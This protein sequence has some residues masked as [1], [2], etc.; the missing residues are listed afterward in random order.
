MTIATSVFGQKFLKLSSTKKPIEF[1]EMQRQ[2]NDWKKTHELKKEKGWKYFKRWENEM[3]MHTDASGNPVDSKIML[4]EI[5]KNTNTKINKSANK[6]FAVGWYPFGPNSVPN[7]LTGY[8]ENGIGRINCIA[9]EPGNSSTYYI[10]VGQGGVWKTTNNGLNWTPLTDNLPI[11]RVSDIA[12]DPNNTSTMYISLCDFEYVGIGLHLNGRKRN[13]HYGLG[14]YKTT[15]GGMNWQPTGLAFQLTQGDESLIRKIIVNQQ[16]SSK[17][18]ACG[19]NGMFTSNDGGTNWTKTMD[20]LFWDMVQDPVNPNMLFAAT[21]WINNSQDGF[22]AIYKSLDFGATWSMLT[23]GIPGT[24]VVQRVK[25]AISPSDP[26]YLYALTV[27]LSS[28]LHGI[29][30]TTN[31]GVSWNFIAPALNI[32]EYDEGFG[33]GGQGNYDL[34]FI[35]DATNRDK[36][37]AGGVNMWMSVDGCQNFNPVSH[38]TTSYGPTIHA[39]IHQIAQQP[40]TGN[41]FVCS[42]G[43]INR[44]TNVSSITWTDAQNGTQWPT[45]WANLS[46]GMQT[47]SFYRLSSSKTSTEVVVAGAQ[48]NATFLYDGSSWKTVYGGDGMDNWIDPADNNWIIASAQYGSFGLSMDGGNSFSGINPDASGS[49]NGE[50]TTPIIADDNSTGVL[51]A[52]Y[53][54]VSKSTDHGFNWSSISAFPPDPNSFYETEISALAVANTNPDVVVAAKRV[55]YEYATP[56]ALYHTSNGGT[57]WNDVTLGLPDSLYYTSVE[58]S[59]TDQNTFYITMA[60]FTSGMKVFKTSNAG[61]S[62]QN[63]SYNLPNIPTNCIKQIPGTNDLM[64][65]T[66]IGVYVLPANSTTWN[67]TSTGL[68]NVIISDIEFN[69]ALNKVYI[70]TFGRGIWTADLSEFISVKNNNVDVTKFELFPSPNSGSFKIKAPKSY[71]SKTPIKVEI[72]DICGKVVHQSNF[73]SEEIMNFDLKLNPGLYHAK[74]T[75]EKLYGVKSFVV[76]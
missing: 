5:L 51:Y 25:L 9:F 46:N 3:Q 19:V 52:G 2:F 66:D 15:D 74:I 48:D 4:T 64:L 34:G 71:K 62:W 23:T 63:I 76:Q 75:G 12:I 59:E 44:T 39:D 38:W 18:V 50:W 42:D 58:I 69:I 37:Y 10:G 65:A 26:N 57:T 27:D 56:G 43:G 36:I 16:N 8:M 61:S 35:V 1:K 31:A 28:G 14:V 55:R 22:A 45:V 7:N 49:G 24:G 30:K 32:L 6:S 17:L 67:L 20:S 41:V 68:P 40:G 21:G 13:T 70:A 53:A 60:G 72:I 47:T 54:N 29:Y 33:T 11:T 73:N